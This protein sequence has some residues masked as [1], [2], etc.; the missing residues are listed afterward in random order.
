M[1]SQAVHN[2]RER[3]AGLLLA[4]RGRSGL[5][6]QALAGEAGVSRGAVQDWEAGAN[7]PTADRL[8]SV[9]GA[10]VRAAALVSGEER[11]EAEAMWAAALRESPRLRTPFDAIWFEA[12]IRQTAT[13][14]VAAAYYR[15][16]VQ[17]ER[18]KTNG[19]FG[20]NRTLV[21]VT[22]NRGLATAMSCEA[23]WLSIVVGLG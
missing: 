19:Q 7:V 16:Y 23:R 9:I 5:T 6:Q 21:S 17:A 10:L 15:E 8:K 18:R 20:A 14:P 2:A 11:N 22:P 12:P 13:A 3:F 4:C 1:A